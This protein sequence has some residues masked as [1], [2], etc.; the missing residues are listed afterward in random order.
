MKILRITVASAILLTSH[1]RAEV[2]NVKITKNV[3]TG[4]GLAGPGTTW[5]N[6]TGSSGTKKRSLIN[7]N[8][9]ITPI[10]IQVTYG[11]GF[12]PTTAAGLTDAPERLLGS[13]LYGP[14]SFTLSGLSASN[15]YTIFTF[16]YDKAGRATTTQLSGVSTT[17]QTPTSTIISS[18]FI[19]GGNFLRFAAV[20][21]S[22]T[23]TIVCSSSVAWG[24][25]NAIQIV[26]VSAPKIPVWT[27]VISP[28]TPTNGPRISGVLTDGPEAGLARIEASVDLGIAATWRPVATLRLDSFGAATFTSIEDTGLSGL[29]PQ[30]H[31]FRAVTTP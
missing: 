14:F 2:I 27:T 13:G 19:E 4:T 28:P 22:A 16:H 10:A 24:G 3:Y 8:G 1:T 11:S 29:I 25:L 26:S 20:S 18:S 30:T 5:N 21:P 15:K 12:G 6:F 17:S 9:T 31:F 23:G 7:S